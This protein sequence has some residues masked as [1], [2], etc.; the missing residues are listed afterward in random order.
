MT[1]SNEKDTDRFAPQALLA[2]FTK[3]R[4]VRCLAIAL[5]VHVVI[6]G[7]SSLDYVYFSWINPEAGRAR[8]EAQ[9]K[10]REA[11]AAKARGEVTQ[12]SSPAENG[13]AGTAKTGSDQETIEKNKTNPVIQEITETANPE[14]IP[15]RPE[16]LGISIDETSSY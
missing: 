10:A 5:A 6:I 2:E 12:P 3:N 7:G 16:D 14:D 9:K 4:I 13:K 1:E 11:E 15:D 8:E